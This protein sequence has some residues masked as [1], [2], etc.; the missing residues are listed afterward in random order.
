[1]IRINLLPTR[2]AKKKDLGNKQLV[3][4]GLLVVGALMGNW[5]WYSGVESTLAQ[6]NAQ[7]AKLKQ[8]IAQLDKIIGEVNTIKEQKKAL[9]EKLAVLDKLRKGR[10]GPVKMLDALS[11]LMPEKVW[12][13]AIEEKGGAMVIRGGAVTNEDLAD[14]MR[15]LKKNPFFSEPSL[16]KSQQVGDRQLG[17]YVQFELSCSINYAA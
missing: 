16:K 14:L 4:L 9:E 2:Q 7:V 3:L 6:K 8:D 17:T 15:E 13:S 1:M 12:I 11:T 10:T 5:F